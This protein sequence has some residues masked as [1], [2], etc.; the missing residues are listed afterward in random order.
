MA[1]I[2]RDTGCETA[3]QHTSEYPMLCYIVVV[4]IDYVLMS[5][6]CSMVAVRR[7]RMR[8][9]HFNY[10]YNLLCGVISVLVLHRV[11]DRFPDRLYVAY[12]N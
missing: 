11:R 7:R 3:S 2:F 9:A 8:H 12:Y 5:L 6:I 10:T 4:V 1:G